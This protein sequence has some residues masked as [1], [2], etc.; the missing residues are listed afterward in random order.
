MLR[1]LH[2]VSGNGSQI[3]ER[4]GGWKGRRDIDW[5]HGSKG[6]QTISSHDQSGG[7]GIS[8]ETSMQ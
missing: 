1:T 7:Q 8:L 4:D 5:I 3:V 2:S 6:H